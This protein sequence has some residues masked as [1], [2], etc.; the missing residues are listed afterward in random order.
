[1]VPDDTCPTCG[2]QM[3]PRTG[4]FDHRVN[5]EEIFVSGIPHLDCP[6]CHEKLFTLEQMRMI[7]QGAYEIYR[8]KYGLLSPEEIRAIREKHGLTQAAFAK[9]LRLGD[10]TVSRW[11]A[12]R[13][14]QTAAMD[15][16][17]R[18]IRDLPG[19]LAYLRRRRAA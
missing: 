8:K 18:L 17:L 15:T 7:D 3:R 6:R 12:N 16:L 13:N 14:V 11:E 10:N 5:G 19:S 2:A 1:M 4:R 9:L